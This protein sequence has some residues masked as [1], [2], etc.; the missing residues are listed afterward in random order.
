MSARAP[1]GDAAA[2]LVS[3]AVVRSSETVVQASYQAQVEPWWQVQPDVQSVVNPAA[4]T[5]EG[6]SA[7]L[8]CSGCGAW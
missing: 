1:V 2:T 4:R 6:Q 3:P 7:T 8:P 5:A